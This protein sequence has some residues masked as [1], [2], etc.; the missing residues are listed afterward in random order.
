MTWYSAHIITYVKFLDEHQDTYPIRENVILIDAATPGEAYE[1]AETEGRE[2]ACAND[3]MTWEDR[4]PVL[5]F[6]GVRKVMELRRLHNTAGT[7][8]HCAEV[9]YSKLEAVDEKTLRDFA[10]GMAVNI[11][12]VD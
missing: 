2:I 3:Q 12:Y 5:E 11:R 10:T 7:P 9:S 4:Q 8:A 1:I 6:A